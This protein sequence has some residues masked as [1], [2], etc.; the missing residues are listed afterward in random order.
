MPIVQ[1]VVG[2]YWTT[3]LENANVGDCG[4]VFFTHFTCELIDGNRAVEDVVIKCMR[5][6][7]SLKFLVAGEIYTTTIA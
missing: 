7:L 3:R 2:H 1:I 6:T 5:K 4:W